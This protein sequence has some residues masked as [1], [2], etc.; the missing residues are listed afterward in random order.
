[1]RRI[2]HLAIP[3]AALVACVGVAYTVHR[4]GVSLLETARTQS[5]FLSSAVHV[6]FACPK[7]APERECYEEFY[8]A[9]VKRDGVNAAV[10]DLKARF[11]RNEMSSLDCHYILHAIAFAQWEKT[12][13]MTEAFVYGD[14]LCLGGYYH[15]IVIR[16][17]DEEGTLGGPE[18]MRRACEPLIAQGKSVY[19]M[20]KCAHGLGHGIMLSTNHDLERSLSFC[21]TLPHPYMLDDCEQS[22]FMEYAFE[23]EKDPNMPLFP[24][25]EVTAS[26]AQSCFSMHSIYLLDMA[27]W[28]THD[29]LALCDSLQSTPHRQACYRG[30]GK[31]ASTAVPLND[32][33]GPNPVCGRAGTS[34]QYEWCAMG[35]LENLVYY[36]TS[37][38][39]IAPFC[40]RLPS[41]MRERCRVHGEE[42][43]RKNFEGKE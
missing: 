30:V 31:S 39:A 40:E 15:G 34:E 2:P 35:T 6:P 18:V 13:A 32:I 21:A 25:N 12:P 22:V 4:S 38:T 29:A 23:G 42:I 8:R 14:A 5:P 17:A 1:M 43:Y 19:D 27:Q 33:R 11:Y 20:S 36:T 9:V 24:C 28:R 7:E 37:R 3:L 41:A 10:S 16:A 26:H